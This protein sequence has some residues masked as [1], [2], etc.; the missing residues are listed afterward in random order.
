MAKRVKSH[1]PVPK[2]IPNWEHADET[3]RRIGELMSGIAKAEDAARDKINKVKQELAARTKDMQESV[4]LHTQSLEMFCDS[5]KGD[6][7]KGR[8]KKLNFGTLGWR[9]SKSVSVTKKTVEKIKEVFGR[10][11]ATYIHVKETP[12]KE[13]LA[14]LTDEQLVDVGARRKVTDDFFVEPDLVEAAKL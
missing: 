11:A 14:K 2:V 1:S 7:G 8:S 13:A 10:K 4:D 12:D 9:K 5:H 6:F 3:I